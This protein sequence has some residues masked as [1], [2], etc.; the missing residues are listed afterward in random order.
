MTSPADDYQNCPW[1]GFWRSLPPVPG[2]SHQH[3]VCARCAGCWA[4]NPHQYATDAF[5]A[6]AVAHG[7]V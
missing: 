5:E 2:D 1:C 3:R 6:W 4:K 7:D